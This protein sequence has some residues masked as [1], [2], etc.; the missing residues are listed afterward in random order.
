M[1]MAA[2]REENFVVWWDLEIRVGEDFRTALDTMLDATRSVVVLW[3]QASVHARWV[4]E[5]ADHAQERGT[6]IPACIDDVKPP[7]GFRS[8]QFA[9]LTGF[10]GD[11]QHPGFRKLCDAIR[12]VIAAPAPEVAREQAGA[13]AGVAGI[14][15]A[16]VTTPVVGEEA[17]PRAAAGDSRRR[18]WLLS[19][20]A[21]G[22]LMLAAVLIP[23]RGETKT[24]H[25]ELPYRRIHAGRFMMGCD[26][27]EPDERPAHE[28][29]VTSDFWITQTEVTV[30]AYRRFALA[31]GRAMPPQTSRPE[32]DPAQ[33][34]PQWRDG[35][36]PIVNVSH[37]DATQYCRWAGGRLPWSQGDLPTEAQWEYAA[38]GGTTGL[39]FPWG[40]EISRDKANYGYKDP[41]TGDIYPRASERGAR[42]RWLF[43]SPV[44]SFDPNGFGLYDMVGNVQEWC[45]DAFRPYDVAQQNDPVAAPFS[46]SDERVVRGGSFLYDQ[47]DS[48]VENRS[49][50][51]PDGRY[52]DTGFRCVLPVRHLW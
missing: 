50:N 6:L 3:S 5:E 15:D 32:A 27:C 47:D 11:R 2:L 18:R 44:G 41:K 25:D 14:D 12:Q 13:A 42:D 21:V 23:E 28:I 37:D 38:R 46:P 1:I 49:K 33:F 48:R 24:G 26:R 35:S 8:T 36:H 17:A 39:S 30:D 51:P 52:P 19:G 31:T 22:V 29:N 7:I 9:V 45:R 40:N 16:L 34:N 43:T 20:A 10:N 4:R